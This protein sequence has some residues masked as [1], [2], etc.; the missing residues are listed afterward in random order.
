MLYTNTKNESARLGLVIQVRRKFILTKIDTAF[1]VVWNEVQLRPTE[2]TGAISIYILIEGLPEFSICM[3]AVFRG[4]NMLY[5]TLDISACPRT[6]W[7][8]GNY[9]TLRTL[10]NPLRIVSI[11]GHNS[12]STQWTCSWFLAPPCQTREI[13]K[14]QRHPTRTTEYDFT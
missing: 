11:K 3:Y 14:L 9:V 1:D 4:R 6:W 8:H 2:S 13:L 7:A 5:H 10:I 12:H